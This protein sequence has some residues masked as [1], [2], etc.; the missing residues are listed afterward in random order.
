T[1]LAGKIDEARMIRA[2]AR[3][4]IERERPEAA[5]ASLLREALGAGAAV[6]P[7]RSSSVLGDIAH[8]TLR[9]V[10]LVTISLI[11]A[12]LVGIPLGVLATRSRF[13]ATVTLAGAGLLQTI[14]S[15]ALL[16]FLIPF[17]GIGLLP[18]LVALFLYSLLPI[19][20]N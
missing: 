13:L 6:A 14:P 11:A 9:H 17:L 2:N 10:Q 5:A 15:M 8:N 1:R 12:I 18:A 4:E 3:V 16:A 20:R 7:S 19:V